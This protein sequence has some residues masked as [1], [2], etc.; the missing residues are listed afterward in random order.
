MVNESGSAVIMF[1]FDNLIID[2]DYVEECVGRNY[3]QLAKEYLGVDRAY[4]IF[5][6]PFGATSYA[7]DYI[8]RR[9]LSENR[10]YV[11]V[12]TVKD[13]AQFLYNQAISSRKLGTVKGE[14]NKEFAQ[15]LNYQ[16]PTPPVMVEQQNLFDLPEQK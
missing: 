15:L 3:I 12:L 2:S 1:Q 14:I 7:E 8:K 6:A 16:F 11:G 13:L 4:L 10:G 9:L 5:V